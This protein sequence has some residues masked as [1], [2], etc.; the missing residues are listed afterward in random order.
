MLPKRKGCT[1]VIITYTKHNRIVNENLDQLRPI[2][3]I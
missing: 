2:V 1:M 3:K